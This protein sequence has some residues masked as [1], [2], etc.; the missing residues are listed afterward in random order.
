MPYIEMKS[1][2]SKVLGV[3]KKHKATSRS[4][5]ALSK[6][7]EHMESMTTATSHTCHDDEKHQ[8]GKE[9]FFLVDLDNLSFLC[10]QSFFGLLSLM[11][12]SVSSGLDTFARD[13][14]TNEPAQKL[15]EDT[16]QCQSSQ[17]QAFVSSVDGSESVEKLVRFDICVADFHLSF[18][19]RIDEQLFYCRKLLA[20]ISQTRIQYFHLF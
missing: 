14:E 15:V 12:V 5:C 1:K 8:L 19:S 11:I 10:Y 3:C 9:R 20:I 2:I 13:I 7:S 6:L 18:L 17:C 16:S 4:S